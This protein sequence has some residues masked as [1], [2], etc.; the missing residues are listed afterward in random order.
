MADAAS[1]PDLLREARGLLALQ[2]AIVGPTRYRAGAEPAAAAALAEERPEWE[3]PDDEPPLLAEAA[4][5][6]PDEPPL[7]AGQRQAEGHLPTAAPPET[8]RRGGAA[9][10][11]PEP[12]EAAPPPDAPASPDDV[13]DLFGALPDPSQDEALSPYERIEA[14]IPEDSPLRDMASL[15]EV[16]AWLD[17]TE[18]VPIDRD[19]IHPV[20]GTGDPDADLMIIGEA[21]GADEDRQG[22]PFVG[23]SGQLLD[24]I[25]E[26]VLFKRPE[27][28]ITNILKS[29]P[30]NNRDPL[31][32]EVEAHIPIL[33]K[34]IA[35]V[36][37]KVLLAVG[38][39]AGNGLLG[40]KSSLAS[41]R[42]TF[43][44]FYGLPLLV[45]YHP[46]AL[47]RNP[48]WK[49]PTWEDVKLLRTRYDQLTG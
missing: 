46:A 6:A 21:P 2:R 19:R 26:A 1:L 20:L 11:A 41:L 7:P 37:P 35:L 32:D 40:K 49:R 34:Q 47:L 9:T 23:R 15:D 18:L 29:R 13:P 48:Q 31:A 28:Y 14:L 30:P 44:D 36:R 8:P 27:V 33:Y 25:L 39:S 24:K 17:E 16:Y 12:Q 22:E 5:P 10:P 43:Q 45:T 38:K 4:P 3:P 42:G